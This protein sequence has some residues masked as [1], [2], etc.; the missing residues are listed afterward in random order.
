V[1]NPECGLGGKRDPARFDALTG[2]LSVL[3]E[4]LAFSV[5]LVEPAAK[6]LPGSAKF[7][8]PAKAF[9]ETMSC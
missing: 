6:I 5:N 2:L 1:L 4:F 9:D 8:C 3:H 7:M